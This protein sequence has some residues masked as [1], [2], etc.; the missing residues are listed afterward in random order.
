[1][2]HRDPIID[3]LVV[4]DQ[5]TDQIDA[6]LALARLRSAGVEATTA[7]D[8]RYR[9]MGRSVLGAGA[10]RGTDLMTD[11]VVKVED[12]MAA[13]EVLSAPLPLGFETAELEAWSAD[14]ANRRRRRQ[15]GIRRIVIGIIAI[16][17][18]LVVSV[19]LAGA[20]RHVLSG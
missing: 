5:F 7:F 3:G 6:E 1:M 8:P 14:G 16:L 13:R 18:A 10:T 9:L 4:I 19:F 20:L 2:T 11:L 15:A 12:V 17:L